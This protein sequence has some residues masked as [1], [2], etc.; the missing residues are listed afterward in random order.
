[1]ITGAGFL[2]DQRRRLPTLR[3]W[4]TGERYM[5]HRAPRRPL[6]PRHFGSFTFS[7]KKES[8]LPHRSILK[9]KVG[10]FDALAPLREVRASFNS[11]TADLQRHQELLDREWLEARVGYLNVP[12]DRKQ[13]QACLAATITDINTLRAQSRLSASDAAILR[14]FELRRSWLETANRQPA[15]VTYRHLLDIYGAPFEALYSLAKVRRALT[16]AN[17]HE[18]AVDPERSKLRRLAT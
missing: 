9:C 6:T 11:I 4:R 2:T 18:R 1:M 15:K 7:V 16:K 17:A 10:A 13:R 3:R 14:L 12:R 5:A 8:D